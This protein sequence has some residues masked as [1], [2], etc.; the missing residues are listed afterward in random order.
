M[1]VILSVRRAGCEGQQLDVGDAEDE[2]DDAL[3][4]EDRHLST[5]LHGLLVAGGELARIL[6]RVP[7]TSARHISVGHYNLLY[8][9]DNPSRTRNDSQP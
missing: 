5:A 3:T 2:R 8:R 7:S 6:L 1:R 9:C 4:I